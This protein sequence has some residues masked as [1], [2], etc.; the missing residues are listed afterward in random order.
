MMPGDDVEGD[1]VGQALEEVLVVDDVE[2]DDVEGE[3]DVGDDADD[4]VDV[5]DGPMTVPMMI[6]FL[7]SYLRLQTKPSRVSPSS[8]L[9]S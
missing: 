5:S 7:A 3:V 4:G 2:G 6:P 1:D 9:P 8:C